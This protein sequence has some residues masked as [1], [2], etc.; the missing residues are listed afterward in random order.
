MPVFSTNKRLKIALG[1]F[2]SFTGFLILVVVILTTTGTANLAVVFQSQMMVGAVAFIGLLD[3]FCGFLLVFQEARVKR[4]VSSHK[5]Q[6][7][8]DVD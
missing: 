8:Y 6:P 3:V 4:L 5:Q 2:V 1:G 7:D